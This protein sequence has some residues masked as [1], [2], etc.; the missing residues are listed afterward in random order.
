MS[1]DPFDDDG[2]VLSEQQ[3]DFVKHLGAEIE[4]SQSSTRAKKRWRCSREDLTEILEDV[5]HPDWCETEDFDSV[6]RGGE[7]PREGHDDA[8]QRFFVEKCFPDKSQAFKCHHLN[9]ARGLHRCPQ[10]PCVSSASGGVVSVDLA[11]ASAFLENNFGLMCEVVAVT[12]D[13][14]QKIPF[15]FT[16][17]FDGVPGDRDNILLND[18]IANLGLLS[19]FRD[20]AKSHR[21]PLFDVKSAAPDAATDTDTSTIALSSTTATDKATVGGG[22]SSLKDGGCD[23]NDDDGDDLI[24]LMSSIVLKSAEE[25]MSEA[26]SDPLL[27]SSVQLHANAGDVAIDP[28]ARRRVLV[29]RSNIQ[30]LTRAGIRGLLRRGGVAYESGTIF[31]EIRGI[32]KVF[33]ENMLR[34]ALSHVKYRSAEAVGIEDM[35]FS[36]PLGK[37]MLGFGGCKNVRHVWSDMVSKVL[38]QVHPNLEIDSKAMSVL[39]D[40]N[41]FIL[42]EVMRSAADIPQMGR[43]G[44][45]YQGQDGD[46][47]DNRAFCVKVYQAGVPPLN[48]HSVKLFSKNGRTDVKDIPH[49]YEA[50]AEPVWCVNHRTIETVIGRFFPG[51]LAKHGIAEGTKAIRKFASGK[52][53]ATLCA[54]AG[55]QF[56]PEVVALVAGRLVPNVSLFDEAAV[57]LA[58]AVEYMTAEL[59]ELAGNAARDNNRTAISCRDLL[60]AIANDEELNKMMRRCVIRE[61]GVLPG[62]HAALLPK[63]E[64]TKEEEEEEE[65]FRE[66]MSVMV[67]KARKTA[68][69]VNCPCAV[70]IDPCTGLHL[71]VDE[72]DG[73]VPMPALDA[74]SKETQEER[75]ALAHAAL[76]EDERTTMRKKGYCAIAPVDTRSVPAMPPLRLIAKRR[77]SEIQRMQRSTG[78]VFPHRA[79]QRLMDEI[80]QDYGYDLT[81]TAEAVECAQAYTEEYVV[82]LA[83]DAN[84][85][86]LSA[87]RTMILPKDLQLSRRIG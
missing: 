80:A 67:A 6:L 36:K 65:E 22:K 25:L 70:F 21:S 62:I 14:R 39:N 69:A 2:V 59:I 30:C 71:A 64:E 27:R 78:F 12:S 53:V 57:Y 26:L 66:F 51:E 50:L 47:H 7:S 5:F 13:L 10:L 81:F 61:S 28:H 40:I 34:D 79:F 48:E 8:Y 18:L 63:Y 77:L 31:E 85:C 68:A 56:R 24:P 43:A 44:S 29:L 23:N 46:E 16:S 60:L 73:L 87:S 82:S 15:K 9:V 55:L 17:P 1:C 72:E 20:H 19:T 49:E 45:A 74:F 84:L 42:S 32:A 52:G 86:A 76:T 75:M 58:A 37:T 3:A 83:E 38:K 33:M 11:A 4:I 35:L 54:R 41:T